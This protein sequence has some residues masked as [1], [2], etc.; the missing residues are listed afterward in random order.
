MSKCSAVSNPL[1]TR[2]PSPD[3]VDLLMCRDV[4]DPELP[5]QWLQTTLAL[6]FYAH[7]C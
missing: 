6:V 3:E 5:K 4:M 7:M 2:L 1:R